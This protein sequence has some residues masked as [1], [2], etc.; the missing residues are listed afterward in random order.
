MEGQD[1][2]LRMQNSL[3]EISNEVANAM[4]DFQ[5][6]QKELSALASH[7]IQQQEKILS[8]QDLIVLKQSETQEVRFSLFF[9]ATTD[10][11]YKK[12]HVNELK[13]SAE[14]AQEQLHELVDHQ[15]EAFSEA[16]I[17]IENLQNHSEMTLQQLSLHSKSIEEAQATL[18]SALQD[19]LTFQKNFFGE[20]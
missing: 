8:Q 6:E 12:Q 4:S 3:L 5:K 18:K 10:P 14:S 16:F 17:S 7:S 9:S 20:F 1:L 11:N 13:E 2:L 15:R 19:V